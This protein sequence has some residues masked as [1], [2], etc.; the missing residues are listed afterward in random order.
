MG[1]ERQCWPCN[2]PFWVGLVVSFGCWQGWRCVGVVFV[3]LFFR[4]VGENGGGGGAVC[5]ECLL[6]NSLVC[7]PGS[8]CVCILS[9]TFTLPS[10]NFPKEG[11]LCCS[12]FLDCWIILDRGCLQNSVRDASCH[13]WWCCFVFVEFW[14]CAQDCS[15]FL[16]RRGPGIWSH[17]PKHQWHPNA[18]CC[19][20][21][22]R[23]TVIHTAVL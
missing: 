2:H 15:C 12:H 20:L 16:S 14:G 9:F 4:G 18:E 23:E 8:C 13:C 21:W 1:T 3:F 5:Y 19:G 11:L 10:G 22:N 17:H 6:D 7:L